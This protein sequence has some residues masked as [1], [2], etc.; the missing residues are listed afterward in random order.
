M[1]AVIEADATT[2]EKTMRAVESDIQRQ[3]F[4]NV[5]HLETIV[6]NGAEERG[7]DA[8]R[9]AQ[10]LS[11]VVADHQIAVDQEHVQ[12]SGEMGKGETLVAKA[13]EDIGRDATNEAAMI[14]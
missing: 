8:H 1:N 6:S 11:N 10:L 14:K 3:L 12:A 13:A 7:A 9:S 2:Q 4:T 5:N